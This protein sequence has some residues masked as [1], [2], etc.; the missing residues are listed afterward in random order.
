[1]C[2]SHFNTASSFLKYKD[3][4]SLNIKCLKKPLFLAK[5]NIYLVLLG[6]DDPSKCIACSLDVH[7][8]NKSLNTTLNHL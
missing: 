5:I 2:L 3:I 4:P 6:F 1:M 7:T 8:P